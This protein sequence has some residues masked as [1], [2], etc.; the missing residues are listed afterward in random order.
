MV[1]Y[2][3]W[4]QFAERVGAAK[5][6]VDWLTAHYLIV[7]G[8]QVGTQM[9]SLRHMRDDAPGPEGIPLEYCYGSGVCL[10]FRHIPCGQNI[11]VRGV[12]L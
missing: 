3:S 11:H 5:F 1:M 8:D 10:D 4:Q 12:S 9:D 6:G 7:L 2:E